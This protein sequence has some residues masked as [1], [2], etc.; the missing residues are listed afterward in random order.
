[1]PH[2]VDT[3][4][5]SQQPSDEKETRIQKISLETFREAR[6]RAK[7]RLQNKRSQYD[8]KWVLDGN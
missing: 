5:T 7:C 2:K 3:D 1:M 8:N 6:E 4:T